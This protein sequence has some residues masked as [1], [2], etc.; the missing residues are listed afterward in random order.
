MVDR[1]YLDTSVFTSLALLEEQADAIVSA[2][3]EVRQDPI[4]SD[5]GWGE[6]LAALG[7]R[8][9]NDTVRAEPAREI[10]GRMRSQLKAA[11]ITSMERADLV[12][13][14]G[15][16]S[17]FSLALKL[18]D[19][20]HIAIAHRLGA[21]LVSTDRQQIAAAVALNVACLNPVSETL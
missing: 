14:T 19:A 15:M 11:T 20:I 16:V 10:V 9:R 6:F 3:A 5:F 12:A 21:I 7:A 4:T 2:L 18:P 1:V 8:V 13:A 17:D